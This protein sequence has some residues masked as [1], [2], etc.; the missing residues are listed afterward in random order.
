MVRFCIIFGAVCGN[1]YFNSRYYGFQT[2]EKRFAVITTFRL[3][4]SVK[5]GICG[6]DSFERSAFN[7]LASAS[8]VFCFYNASE[9]IISVYNLTQWF[10]IMAF[11]S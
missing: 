5:K 10:A 2:L 1:F 11:S 3:Q 4:F 9:F 7:C 8:Q 6:D